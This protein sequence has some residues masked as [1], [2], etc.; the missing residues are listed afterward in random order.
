M[1]SL[2]ARFINQIA[3]LSKKFGDNP[4]AKEFQKASDKFD[5]LVELGL[6]EKRGYNLLSPTDAHI[7]SHFRFNAK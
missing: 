3:S 5:E 7:K 6:A 2:E 4:Q 1:D